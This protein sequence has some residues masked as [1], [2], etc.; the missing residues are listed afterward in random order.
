M[1]DS[2]L[3]I[4]EMHYGDGVA[5]RS[6][7]SLINHIHEGLEIIERRF[8]HSSWT[9]QHQDNVKAAYCLHPLFQNDNEL[10]ENYS[11]L[12]LFSSDIVMWVME[13]RNIANEGLRK[14]IIDNGV[15]L[16]RPNISPLTEVNIMLIGD[17]V[18][19]RKDFLKH[20]DGRHKDSKDLRLYFEVW[21]EVLGIT[22]VYYHTLTDRL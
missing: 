12:G 11:L 22:D 2:A 16:R 6:R 7:V 3:R 9:T 4:I 21:M 20:H 5:E 10:S 18:Q 19:N 8:T 13:Y 14:N 15:V 17:K 1:L